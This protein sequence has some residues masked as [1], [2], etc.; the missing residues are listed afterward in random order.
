MISYYI[1]NGLFGIRLQLYIILLYYIAV[2]VN[3]SFKWYLNFPILENY[4][5]LTLSTF[6]LKY[7]NV[8]LPSDLHKIS[9]KILACASI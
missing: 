6:L 9:Y 5:S 4:K 3:K 7:L 1:L 8:Q 2:N